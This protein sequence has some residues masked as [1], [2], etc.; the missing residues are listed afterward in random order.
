MK[1]NRVNIAVL[2]KGCPKG[3]K[4]YSPICGDVTLERVTIECIVINLHDNVTDLD[5]TLYFDKY[6]R[7]FVV[8]ANYFGE[9]LLFPSKEIRDWN[10][11]QV[12]YIIGTSDYCKNFKLLNL[13]TNDQ[14]VIDEFE[15]EVPNIDGLT[16]FLGS[17][18]G[19]LH[20]ADYNYIPFNGTELKL[21]ERMDFKV[22]DVVRQLEAS[23]LNTMSVVVDKHSHRLYEVE[24]GFA[25]RQ[26]EDNIYITATP[27][28]IKRW[29]EE[30]L[31]PGRLHYSTSKRKIIDWFSL[32]DDVVVRNPSLSDSEW[33]LCTFSHYNRRDNTYCASGSHWEQ[34]LP[35]NE[36]TAK[37][38]GTTNSYKGSNYVDCKR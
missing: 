21:E 15:T 1:H 14:K 29:N 20:W 6:G 37:L 8:G 25:N 27:E 32:K 33:R 10:E 7:I 24:V 26:N 2:L 17:I 5:S 11:F 19:K 12:K 16:V 18:D 31:Q 30:V 22:G 9:C 36:K 38:I 23:V 4:L 3:T 13:L 34:C 28:E 35:Y